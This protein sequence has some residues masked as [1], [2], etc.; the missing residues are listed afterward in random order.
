M[1]PAMGDVLLGVLSRD[2]PGAPGVRFVDP[3]ILQ[4]AGLLADLI[5]EELT[6]RAWFTSDA[7][8][9]DM[10]L[11]PD[12]TVPAARDHLAGAK[13]GKPERLVYQG[14]VF[15]QQAAASTRER[16][17]VQVGLEDY[18]ALDEVTAD[19]RIVRAASAAMDEAGAGH[20][21]FRFGDLALFQSFL[22]GLGIDPSV[23]RG[24][25]GA[26]AKPGGVDAA[27]RRASAETEPPSAFVR[28]I[29]SLDRAE[30]LALVDDRIQSS[31]LL[32]AGRSCE[33]VL[34]RLLSQGTRGDSRQLDPRQ[35]DAVAAYCQIKGPAIAAL[36]DVMRLAEQHG[37]DLSAARER[38][39]GLLDEAK[40]RPTIFA[41]GLSRALEYY[42]GIVFEIE[43]ATLGERSILGGGGRMNSLLSRL[44]RGAVDAPAVGL[45]LR[46]QRISEVAK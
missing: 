25:V 32:L 30:A 14:I 44:S 12:V 2:V 42:D 4:P 29:A 20:A 39:S 22:L 1:T 33:E 21:T 13:A 40:G 16:E 46:P 11:R 9:P 34:E 19:R 5:G 27:I 45:A 26:G 41:A 28:T 17:F 23:A 35:A 6:R 37:V 7:Q 36:D 43:D 24:L 38:W 31:G 18:C 10:V 3:P 8:G 15:R